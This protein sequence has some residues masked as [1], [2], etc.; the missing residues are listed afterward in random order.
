MKRGAILV[1]L[2]FIFTSTSASAAEVAWRGTLSIDFVNLAPIHIEGAGVA[3]VQGAGIGL[4]SLHLNGGITG[5][6][7][8]PVSNAPDP[9]FTVSVGASVELSAGTLGPFWPPQPLTANTLPVGGFAKLCI[10]FPGCGLYMGLP[11]SE[12]GGQTAVGVGG[13]LTIGGSGP[14]RISVDAA[15]W[16]VGTTSVSFPTSGGDVV[17]VTARGW[18]HG[19]ASFAGSTALTGGALSV[20]TPI[21]VTS[22]SSGQPLTSFGRLQLRFVPEPTRCVL[23]VAGAVGLGLMGRS[24][25]P[26]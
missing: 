16:T 17:E 10:F 18:A 12:N 19:P 9:N 6:G 23:L 24:R 1:A 3:T 26:G 7:L 22:G 21:Q 20:V 2:I 5:A 25:R 11:L 8:T 15:P 14:V 4:D 13:L